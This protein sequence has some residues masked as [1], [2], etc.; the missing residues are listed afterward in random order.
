MIQQTTNKATIKAVVKANHLELNTKYFYIENGDKNNV[1]E[2]I[3]TYLQY[4]KRLFILKYISVLVL[5]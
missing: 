1:G 2:N 3:P 4:K 5:A